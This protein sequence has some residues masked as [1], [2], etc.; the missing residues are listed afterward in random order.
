VD[1]HYK[2]PKVD[3]WNFTI[4]RDL[5][6]GMGLRLTYN[7]NHG[8]NLGRQGALGQLPPNTT[9]FVQN[10]PVLEFPNWA[11]INYETNDGRQ[12]YNGLTAVVTKRL[13][14]GL[15]FTSSYAFVRNLTNA[16]GYNPNG[17]AGEA[18]GQVTDL[19]DK[20]IDYG[21]VQFSRRHRFL[22]TFLYELP[23]P[24]TPVVRQVV[25]GWQLGGV[26][27]FQS[28]PF[29]TVP[30][31]DPMGSGLPTIKSAERADLNPGVPLYA[32][33]KNV[34][35]WI[36]PSAF[37]VPPSR[38]GRFPTA[39]V[40]NVMG[41][42]TEVISMSITKTVRIREGVQFRI[43]AQAANLL[44]HTNWAPPNTTFNTAPFG[45]IS[46]VQSA[47]G[48]GPRQIQITSRLTF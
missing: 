48:A 1:V 11:W 47:E 36:N 44:N 10:S 34:Q 9:G 13:S 15:Q 30:G 25:G 38:V 35:H 31:A 22:T 40:G 27:L 32:T 5:G 46:N 20:Q 16:Q 41:P 37:A 39:P 6:A 8:R 4:E 26:M 18:G 14:K 28:G 42:G 43:G 24:K 45:T 19:R 21:N 7:G 23:S 12:N 17:F 29:L 3:E 33:T 2:D